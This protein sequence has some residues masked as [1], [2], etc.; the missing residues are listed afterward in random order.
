[1]HVVTMEHYHRW[2]ETRQR[3]QTLLG[4][5]L[6]INDIGKVTLK[7]SDTWKAT[8]KL[9]KSILNKKEKEQRNKQTQVITYYTGT[10]NV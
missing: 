9:A 2:E 1:M 4:L 7:G 5:F 10:N 8:S 3:T 6:S